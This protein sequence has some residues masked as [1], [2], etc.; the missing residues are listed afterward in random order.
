M[1]LKSRIKLK[2]GGKYILA[3]CSSLAA[4]NKHIH[5]LSLV[6]AQGQKYGAPSANQ[7]Y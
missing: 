7:T 4:S 3:L 2:S 5:L 1:N 6:V